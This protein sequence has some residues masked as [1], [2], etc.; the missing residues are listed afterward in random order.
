MTAAEWPT[1][2]RG[3]VRQP[4][5]WHIDL[6]LDEAGQRTCLA[7]LSDDERARAARFLRLEDRDRYAASHAALRRILASALG[8]NPALLR[9]RLGPSG[10]PE[11]DA[12]WRDRLEFNLSHSG[13]VGLI[14]L[15]PAARIGVDVEWMRPLPDC[16]S[17]ARSHFARPEI[18]ALEA[19]PSAERQAAFY[20]C[21]TR[22]EAFVKALGSGLSFP[23]DGFVVA[24]PPEPPALVSIGGS[25]GAASAWSLQHLDLGAGHVGAVAIE[26]AGAA[27]L[28]RS[29]G[30]DWASRPA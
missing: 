16:L 30:A 19:L 12:P 13:S 14:G 21:W 5:V 25:T 29:L 2:E 15:S 28:F 27:C 7:A 23:L 22:K 17:L 4:T 9:F 18:A 11:L 24:V 6:T 20:A 10:K 26:S 8:T 1:G 3:P